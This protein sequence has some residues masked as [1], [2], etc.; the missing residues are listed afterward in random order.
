MMPPPTSTMVHKKSSRNRPLD[1][2]LISDNENVNESCINRI[3]AEGKAKV[4]NPKT[5]KRKQENV[6]KGV[7][8]EKELVSCFKQFSG[9]ME[10]PKD[11]LPNLIEMS[12]NFMDQAMTRLN[13]QT[14]GAQPK[15]GDWKDL[16]EHYGFI[17][18]GRASTR[19]LYALLA[20]YLSG[21]HVYKLVPMPLQGGKGGYTLP[22]DMWDQRATDDDDTVIPGRQSTYITRVET[23]GRT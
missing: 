8:S 21:E 22:R 18:K 13:E 7:L 15:L 23:R 14:Y 12:D 16:F 17:P 11:V 2:I 19:H 5:R 9:G 4:K 3:M 10:V 6:K 1:S 20:K